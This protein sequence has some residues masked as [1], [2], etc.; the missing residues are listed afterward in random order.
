MAGS[1]L[2]RGRRRRRD[3]RQRDH[4]LSAFGRCRHPDA[5]QLARTAWRALAR[6]AKAVPDRGLYYLLRSS[7]ER[8]GLAPEAD[9]L[10]AIVQLG[11]SGLGRACVANFGD[12]RCDSFHLRV[13]L[14]RLYPGLSHHRLP[15]LGERT[16]L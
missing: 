12:G 14:W 9:H 4:H 11:R 10:L 13:S 6:V 7:L 1:A 5:D 8:T 16:E 3:L 15:G 2:A